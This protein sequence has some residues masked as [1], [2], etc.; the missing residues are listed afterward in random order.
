MT[1]T[2]TPGDPPITPDPP[3][4]EPD[5]AAGSRSLYRTVWRWHF[6]AGLF[7]IPV[8]AILCL[9]GLVW[10]FKPQL[11]GL[12]YGDIQHVTP[13][14]QTVSY[15][16]QVEAALAAHPDATVTALHTPPAADRSTIVEVTSAGGDELM[17]YVD[18]YRGAVLGEIDRATDLSLIAL[19]LHGSLMTGSWLGNSDIG[20]YFIEIVAGW[21]VVLLVT[22]IY[23]WWPRGRRTGLGGT[24]I[25]RFRLKGKRLLWRDVHSITG[26]LFSFITLFFLLTGLAW[27]GWWGPNYLSVATSAVGGY[28]EVETNSRTVGELLPNGQSPWAMGN[29]PL[30]ASQPV[31]PSGGPLAGTLSWDPSEGAPID[32]I[33]AAGQQ[34]GVPHGFSI[35]YPED[36]TGSYGVNYWEDGPQEPNRSAT[37]ARI[38]HIDQYTAQPIASYGWDE[39]GWAAK[40]TSLGIALHEGRELGLLNQLLVAIATVA[41]LVSLATSV[42][43]WRKRRPRGLGAPGKEPNRTLGFG[44]LLVIAMLAILFPLLGASLLAVLVLDTLVIQ[45][46]PKLAAAFGAR[47]RS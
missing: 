17:V 1:T 46:V 47:P 32:A 6:F 28:P 20:D 43:M 15:A 9:S 24:L 10:L 39:Y 12:M 44:L 8:L 21:S 18:P 27:S 4:E 40:A 35:S 7:A 30:A 34:L 23:L 42:V 5:G 33:V 16:Q 2:T 22:G 36:G 11:W 31:P 14:A 19:D 29:V 41:I 45:R 38:S 26:V 37:D 3:T 13:S 25:P